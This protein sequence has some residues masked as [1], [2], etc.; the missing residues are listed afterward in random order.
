MPTPVNA[1]LA[2]N[3]I[4]SGGYVLRL[5]ALNPSTGATVSGVQVGSVSAQVDMGDT[6]PDTGVAAPVDPIFAYGGV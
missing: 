1:G 6:T 2:P 3:L 5:T 4:L